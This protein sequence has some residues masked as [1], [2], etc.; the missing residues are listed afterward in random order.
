MIELFL[1]NN[2]YVR[3]TN[4]KIDKAI[5]FLG[6]TLTLCIRGHIESCILYIVLEGLWIFMLIGN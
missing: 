1:Y 2:I 5:G 6:H 4:L 3:Y